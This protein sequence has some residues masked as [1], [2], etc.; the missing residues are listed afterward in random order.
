MKDAVV[1]SSIVLKWVLSEQDSEL[2]LSLRR[3]YRFK[4][5]DL[6]YAECANALWKLSRKDIISPEARSVAMRA[7]AIDAIEAT[8]SR[9]VAARALD[10]AIE[11]DHPV[12]D[13][14]F[15]ALAERDGCPMITADQT[16]ARKMAGHSIV[17]TTLAEAAAGVTAKQ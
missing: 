9:M 2:A 3:Y 8:P 17:V 16:F 13:C 4:A 5:P 6:L 12:Y 14:L 15:A 1:D 10:L 11:L 7:I